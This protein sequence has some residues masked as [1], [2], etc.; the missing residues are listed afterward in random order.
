MLRKYEE[1]RCLRANWNVM[2]W[3]AMSS[4]QTFYLVVY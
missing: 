1:R 4:E 2:Q 3:G